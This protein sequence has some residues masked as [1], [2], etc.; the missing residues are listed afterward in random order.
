MLRAVPEDN[1]RQEF[2]LTLDEICRGGAE[3]MLAIALEAE[4]DAYLERHREFVNGRLVERSDQGD[5]A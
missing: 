1:A 2:T 3:R 5:A 4:V